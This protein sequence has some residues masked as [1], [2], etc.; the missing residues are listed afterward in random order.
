MPGELL[1]IAKFER[2][3]VSSPHGVRDPRKPARIFAFP[4]AEPAAM[5]HRSYPR[6]RRL[7]IAMSVELA[8]LLLI[9]AAWALWQLVRR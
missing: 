1:H 6:T 5:P 2:D 8:G 7:L 9:A 4:V 3:G